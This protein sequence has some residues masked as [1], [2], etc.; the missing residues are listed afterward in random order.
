MNKKINNLSTDE[1]YI[2]IGKNVA[3]LR[4]E[5]NLSQLELSLEMGNKSPSLVSA[6][7]LYAN[8]RKFNIAQLHKIAKILDI[9]ISEFFKEL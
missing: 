3:R 7:E 9:D 4:S 6:A 5:A 2:L 1:L 8:K